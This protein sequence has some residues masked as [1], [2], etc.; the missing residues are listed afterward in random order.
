MVFHLH[1]K[2]VLLFAQIN[3]GPKAVSGKKITQTRT[4]DGQWS[5]SSDADAAAKSKGCDA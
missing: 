1:R 2:L 3:G 5:C 4:S